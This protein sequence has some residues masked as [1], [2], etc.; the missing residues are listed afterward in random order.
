MNQNGSDFGTKLYPY[1]YAL[2]LSGFRN[3]YMDIWGKI[4][5]TFKL[6]IYV[7]IENVNIMN[8][9]QYDFQ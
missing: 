2:Y 4:E 7:T 8:L 1:P 9:F 6:H 5:A 3:M